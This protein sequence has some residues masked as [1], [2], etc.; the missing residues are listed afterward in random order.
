MVVKHKGASAPAV[1]ACTML[2]NDA[3]FNLGATLVQAN[4][5]VPLNHAS[6]A[7]FCVPSGGSC[8]GQMDIRFTG[9]G[10][11]YRQPLALGI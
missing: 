5:A 4:R 9:L 8:S 6:C 10:P 3:Q 7:K 2:A 1:K 11:Q